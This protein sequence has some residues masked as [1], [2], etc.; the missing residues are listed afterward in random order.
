MRQLIILMVL[1]VTLFNCKPEEQPEWVLVPY[2]NTIETADGV[3]TF[4]KGISI[5]TSDEELHALSEFYTKRFE[6]LGVVVETKSNRVIE[7]QLK[8]SELENEEAY[9]VTI[10]KKKITVTAAH[11]K[12]I[13]YGLTTLWQQLQLS[14]NKVVSCGTISDAPRFGY[15]GFMLDESRHFFGKEKVKQYIDLMASFKLNTFHWHLTDEP[16]WRIEIKALPKL[17]TIGGKGYYKTPDGPVKYYTQEDI[18]EVVAY[19]AERF[20]TIIPEI[21]M[22]GHAT[23]ANKAYPEFS[24]GGSE[25]YPD[26]TFDPG[27]E[28]T[29][30]YLTT[31]LKEVATL[32]PSK[33]VHLGGDEVHFGNEAWHSNA[34]IKELMKREQ[35][36]TLVDVE[37]YFIRRITDSLKTLGKDLAGWDEIVASGVDKQTSMIYWWRHDKTD[38]LEAALKAGYKTV[39][40][41]RRPLYFD[42]VQHDSLK[43][44]RRWDGFNPLKDVYQY[45]DGTHQF[46]EG[47]LKLIAGIQS[48]LWTERL[49]TE[50]WI[51]FMTFPRLVAMAESAWTNEAYKD[52][53]RFDAYLPK[54]Y[55]YLDSQGI[56][57]FDETDLEHQKEPEL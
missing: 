22:P 13:F 25:K 35:L 38:K 52:W 17:A 30:A 21:D 55:A 26:F 20:I 15:R 47:D 29:Y 24:G 53:Q 49:A 27:K 44:G 2:P 48:N 36:E 40:C 18:K 32:F 33:Y 34:G 39:L 16:G 5:T 37:H 4:E 54:L 19:A 46:S 56:Y 57:Y 9:Q 8:T 51:D 23:A 14:Q 11:P 1:I 6:D 3:F 28:E 12:G 50:D 10:S 41:P 43:N 7:L 31:I 42:F 45:P